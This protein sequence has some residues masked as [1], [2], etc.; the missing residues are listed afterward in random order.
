MKRLFAFSLCILLLL[1]ACGREPPA[2]PET[3]SD[4]PEPPAETRLYTITV[5][6]PPE[7][8]TEPPTPAES[9][10]VYRHPEDR[11][12]VETR[13]F[14]ADSAES[15]VHQLTGYRAEELEILE[16]TRFGL[17]EYRFA[18]YDGAQGCLCRADMVLDGQRCYG[19]IFSAPETAGD[20]LMLATE[21]FSTFGLHYDEEAQLLQ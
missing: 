12:A 5:S 4:V 18:W 7:L 15:A 3:V 19:V 6:L 20:S 8:Q 9:G 10:T 2:L 11:Y 17:P 16:T 13:T 1:A 21:V 14:L